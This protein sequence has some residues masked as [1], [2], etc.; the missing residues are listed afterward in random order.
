MV[1]R[2][3]P[4]PTA[5]DH[6]QVGGSL[7]IHATTYVVRQSDQDLYDALKAGEFCYVLTSRQM[8]KSSLRVHTMQRLQAEGIACA[9]IDITKIGSQNLSSDQWYASFIGSLVSGFKLSEQFDLRSWW[10]DRTWLTPIQRLDAFVEQVLLQHISDKIVIFIDEI[11]SVLSLNFPTDDFF[12]WIRAT[13]NDRSDLSDHRL[14]FALLG[15]TTPS[16]LIQDKHRT[17][18]N[19]GQAIH[20]RGFQLNEVQ[21]LAQGL[22]DQVADPLKLLRAILNWTGGQPFL[23]QKLCKL[24]LQTATVVPCGQEVPYIEQLVR[25]RIIENW[26]AQDEPEHLKTVRNRLLQD[27]QRAGRL[28]GL[29]QQILQHGA[30]PPN[31]SPEQMELQLTGAIVLQQGCLQVHNRIYATIFNLQWVER[32]LANLRPYAEMLQAWLLSEE[33]DESRLLRG[34][35]LRDALDWTANKSL[36]DLDYQFLNASQELENREVQLTLAAERQ[37]KQVAEDANQILTLA[38]QKAIRILRTA[39][40]ALSLVSVVTVVAIAVVIRTTR[41]LQASR[42]SLELEQAGALTLQQFQSSELEALLSALQ[43]GQT[44][45]TIVGKQRRLAE[46]PTTKPLLVLQT[47][48][49]RIRER[50]HWDGQQGAIYSSSFSRDGRQMIT[51]GNS[52]TVRF[53]NR[54]G[55]LLHQFQAHPSR[56]RRMVLSADGQRLVTAGRDERIRVWDL[57]GK[58][59]AQFQYFQPVINSL[60]LSPNSQQL[61]IAGEGSTVQLWSLSGVLINTFETAQQGVNS[62]AFSPDAETLVTA[63]QDGTLK[64]WNASGTLLAQW[65]G[66]LNTEQSLNSVS[67][68]P[69]GQQIV[70][71][72]EGGIIRLWSLSGQPLNQWRGSQSPLYSVSFSPTGQ[73]LLTIGEDGAAR[74]WDLNGQELAELRGSE[75]LIASASFSPEG[76]AIVTT[77]RDD[78]MIRLWD[79][80]PPPLEHWRTDHQGTWTV[81]FSPNAQTLATAGQDGTVKFWTLSGKLIR[82]LSGHQAGI[83]SLSFSPDGQQL[84]TVAQDDTVRI[85]QVSSGQLLTV[86]QSHQQGSNGVSFSPTGTSLVTVGEDGSGKLW[87]RAGRQLAQLGKLSEP[88]WSVSF[89][90]DGQRLAIAGKEGA[91]HL[92]TLGGE[93]LA[94]FNAK[95]GWVASVRFHPDGKQIATA[96][97]DGM[98][99]LWNLKGK[100]ENQF[101]SHPSGILSLS[102]SAD[103]QR[104]ATAGQDGTV[105]VWTLSGQQIAEFEGHQGAVYHLSF[106]PDG[107]QLASVGQ[108]DTF[109]RWQVDGLDQLL[110]Q[111]CHWL[112]DYFVTRPQVARSCDTD[113]LGTGL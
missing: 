25:S 44:L 101:R 73:Q 111:G 74:L 18:F 64:L 48:M 93:R 8:G 109:R 6:Y 85:W 4:T 75:G 87:N 58:P 16:S 46:Y 97:K 33:Q 77:G 50:N 94:T 95:Q 10:R 98:V 20:L 89:S 82:I 56:V 78:G 72:G 55:Q 61:A 47:I 60:R 5:S 12:A 1:S 52:G 36:S 45:Q 24:V 41:D 81:G 19:I 11:D 88:A 71:V 70:A 49:S 112:R 113:S 22:T 105:R 17:P 100:L 76:Q 35:A 54:S 102:Y 3:Q 80:S 15:V 106:S 57:K 68:S 34:Q 2:P 63:G 107:T 66:S 51:A 37:A 108:D 39:F 14:T 83:N 32:E 38:Q 99:R 59:V 104:L 29:Y 96:G 65:Q 13:Y 69:D 86:F 9:A 23:T 103:G 67:F 7:P 84:A 62:V 31:D 90:P 42:A 28:L 79:F 26:E 21:P 40:V 27:E 110:V 43:S 91:I 30:I 92:W 53:W